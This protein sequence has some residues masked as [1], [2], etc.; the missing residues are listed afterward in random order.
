MDDGAE[1]KPP[2]PLEF[3]EAAVID[4]MCCCGGGN[5]IRRALW[6]PCQRKQLVDACARARVLAH[7]HINAATLPEGVSAEEF[8]QL[9]RRKPAADGERRKH[10]SDAFEDL[11][12]SFVTQWTT[13]GGGRALGLLCQPAA[14]AVIGKSADFL[15]YRS[16]RLLVSR[17]TA[18]QAPA[19]ADGDAA[20]VVPCKACAVPGQPS[21]RCTLRAGMAYTTAKLGF[22]PD[23]HFMCCSGRS[24]AGRRRADHKR[25]AGMSACCL[26]VRDLVG[27]RGLAKR[28]FIRYHTVHAKPGQTQREQRGG[29]GGAGRPGPVP[30][31][32][33]EAAVDLGE[34]L[35]AGRCRKGGG[36]KRRRVHG[37][38]R[39]TAR[40]VRAQA[41][42]RHSPGRRRA[43]AARC[44]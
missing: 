36:R 14:L 20:P 26:A 21:P 28:L 12:K 9:G 15:H 17:R 22:T 42:G 31:G 8:S 39:G 23:S 13:V 25:F 7:R 18:W 6:I 16:S 41:A 35:P 34:E 44:A 3:L 29:P 30:A 38:W 27:K 5:C 2:L 24:P 11:A 4:A 10:C 19:S 33:Q 43:A 32:H 40:A 37:R 1:L